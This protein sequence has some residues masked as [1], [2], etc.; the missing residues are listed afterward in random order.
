MLVAVRSLG[1]LWW[2]LQVSPGCAH[3]TRLLFDLCPLTLPTPV[4][5]PCHAGVP[6]G[7]GRADLALGSVLVPCAGADGAS[8]EPL[9][10][11]QYVV[12][13]DYQKQE[14]SEISL[15]VGQVVEIIEKNESGTGSWAWHRAL[16]MSRSSPVLSGFSRSETAPGVPRAWGGSSFGL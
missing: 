16:G 7:G 6:G 10:L 1:W 8:G 13:A 5:H 11:E 15:C 9:V 14:S 2:Q 4:A 12:V 3:L